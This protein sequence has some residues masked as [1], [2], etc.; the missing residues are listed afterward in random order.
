MEYR[1]DDRTRSIFASILYF[2]LARFSIFG[3]LHILL[4]LRIIFYSYKNKF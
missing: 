4:I 1:P 2:I 3:F